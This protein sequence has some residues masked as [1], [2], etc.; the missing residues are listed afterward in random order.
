MHMTHRFGVTALILALGG[1]ESP[2]APP[3]QPEPPH[4]PPVVAL[5]S[6]PLRFGRPPHLR[7]T[8]AEYGPLAAHLSAA[9]QHPVEVV[10]PGNY[11]EVVTELGAGELDLALLTPFI[12]VKAK[13]KVPDLRLLATLLGEGAPKYL[14]YIVTRAGSPV[15]RLE[16]LA[17]KRFAFVDT[18]SASGYLFPRALLHEHGIEPERDFAAVAYAGSHPTV[19]EWVM[20]GKVDAGAI[21]STTFAHMK[22]EAIANRLTIVGKTDWIPFDAF[23]AH[24]SLPAPVADQIRETLLGLSVRTAEGRQVLTG[25]TTNSGFVAV[26]DAHYDSVRAAAKR[27]A[28]GKP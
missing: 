14:G 3:S 26:D 11:D 5:P 17:G 16:D 4:P 23:V 21:S 15:T 8:R 12:Y 13:E 27:L 1:C 7:D 6:R 22:G 20:Q 9:I 25:I 10:V 24:P 19:V 18:G 28:S 2:V